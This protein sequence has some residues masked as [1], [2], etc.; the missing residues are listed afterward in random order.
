MVTEIKEMQTIGK[1]TKEGRRRDQ[2]QVTTKNL[3]I[4]RLHGTPLSRSVPQPR[5]KG[6]IGSLSLSVIFLEMVFT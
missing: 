1:E 2:G 5:D 3:K 4:S 6:V